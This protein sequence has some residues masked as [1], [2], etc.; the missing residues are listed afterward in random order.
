MS[1][2]TGFGLVIPAAAL[3]LFLAF[4][5]PG[6]IGEFTS[7]TVTLGLFA[8]PLAG[9]WASGATQ[10][11]VLNGL[12]PVTDAAAYYMDAL[13]LIGGERFSAFSARRSLF[14]GLFTAVLA[15][16]GQ[17]LMAALAVLTAIAAFSCYFAVKE[18]QRTHGAII[19]SFMLLV[20]FLFYRAHS[21]ISMSENLGI[22][23]GALGFGFLWRGASTRDL[24]HIA[25]GLFTT[26]LALNARA[27]AFFMLPI[28]I[29][30]AGRFF[31]DGKFW[32]W[33]ALLISSGAVVFA[34]VL[35]FALTRL[36]AIPSGVPFANFSYTFYGLATGGN[37]WA[38][39]FQAHPEVLLL[40]ENEQPW[41]IYQLAFEVMRSNP[42]LTVKGALFNWGM[43]FSD[44]WYNVYAYVSGENWHVNRIARW[45]MYI[46]ALAG[47][48][49]WIRNR[50]DAL[51]SLVIASI[52][53]VF[54]SVPFLPPT[55]AYRMRPYAASIIILAAL[56]ALGL[57]FIIKKTN[58]K[59]LIDANRAEM[60]APALPVIFNAALIAAT[61]IAP[62]LIFWSAKPT[63][64][65]NT[66]CSSADAESILIRFDEGTFINIKKQ[67][68]NFL[69]WMPNYHAGLFKRNLHDT[70]IET[71]DWAA[72]LEPP[73]TLLYTLDLKNKNG[74]WVILQTDTPPTTGKY[75]QLCGRSEFG[76]HRLT[77]ST[78]FFYADEIIPITP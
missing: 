10:T 3:V 21:G 12:I 50:K 30:W 26:T 16:T 66:A 8:M 46:L 1:L 68:Q 2:R 63:A 76:S 51:N 43:L 22:A 24:N 44:S 33:K 71:M 17:N 72:N 64:L 23:L 11:T 53:G 34:F 7:M 28:L 20:L 48:F 52:F 13:K 18:I 74:T 45:G 37:S 40:P 77:K 54:I 65:K 70:T 49:A 9:L 4:R 39:V 59:F 32:S 15:V 62:V 47:L 25:L 58:L 5:I 55:D 6:R 19:S 78:P 69:D 73:V 42:M 41:R 14:P 57:D 61:L 27:G 31:R 38:Y 75:Y 67:N 36:V 56:P 60:S 35:S 29:L